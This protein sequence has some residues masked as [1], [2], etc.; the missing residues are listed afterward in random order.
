MSYKLRLIGTFDKEPEGHFKF[1]DSYYWSN[2]DHV[3]LSDHYK[4]DWK[5]VRLPVFIFTPG[6]WWSP[7][8]K[9]YDENGWR[10]PG[11]RVVGLFPLISANPSINFPGHYHGWVRDG[12]LT[13]DV[14]GRRWDTLQNRIKTS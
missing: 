5:G 8:Q 10:G 9:A 6:G 14:E 2:D 7:D 11:W 3:S 1:G 12:G 4:K 13:D